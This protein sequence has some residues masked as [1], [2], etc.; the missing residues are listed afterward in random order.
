[1]RS[2]RCP[3]VGTVPG[4]WQGLEQIHARLIPNNSIL[5]PCCNYS[6]SLERMA[7]RVAP[8]HRESPLSSQNIALLLVMA[9]EVLGVQS[10]D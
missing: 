4:M 7:V 5:A 9:C 2:L 8:S 6:C 1:M 10:G 3:M